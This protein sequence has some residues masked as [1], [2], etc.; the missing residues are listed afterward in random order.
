MRGKN[1]NNNNKKQK[2]ATL[3]GVGNVL[4]HLKIKTLNFQIKTICLKAEA[5]YH[6]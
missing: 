4:K 2:D 1:N 5:L 6:Y 3:K